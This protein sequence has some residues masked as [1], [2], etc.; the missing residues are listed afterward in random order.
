MLLTAILLWRAG[1]PRLVVPARP[2]SWATR[3]PAIRVC[4]TIMEHPVSA[5]AVASKACQSRVWT[6]TVS[7][8]NSIRD[9]NKEYRIA[10]EEMGS[11]C[12]GRWGNYHFILTCEHVIHKDA[13][14]PDMRVFWRPYGEDQYKANSELRPDDIASAT[15]IKDP[16]AV[17]H[18]C[19]WEDLAI[20]TI[21]K[22]EAGPHSEFV[23]I[24]NDR[25]DPAVDEPIHVCGYPWDKRILVDDRMI[26]ANR[27]ETTHAVRPD[28]FSGQVMA[29]PTFLTKDFDAD[30]HYLVPYNHPVS[31]HPDGFSGAAAW[32][33]S[34]KMEQVWRPSFKFAGICTHS[35]KDGTFERV[36]KASAV[37]Q[38]L[39]EALGSPTQT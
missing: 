25:V 4:C 19:G 10:S 9:V 11:G 23:D 39:E 36:V 29:G 2:K 24:A 13:K 7:L 12:A 32:W 14:P 34:D 21:D 6:H 37:R 30:R 28:I 16:N 26:S 17:I 3:L 15:P 20:I 38:F 33:E 8:V 5:R 18:R 1:T 35:Y 27:R 31:Q 22:S